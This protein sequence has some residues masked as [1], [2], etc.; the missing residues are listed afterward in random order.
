MAFAGFPKQTIAFLSGLSSHNDKAWFEKHRADYDD[1]FVAVGRAFAE[2]MAAPLRKIDP[3]VH[4]EPASLMR[5]YRDT[6][7]A[8]DKRP[9]KDHL[10]LWFWTGKKKG[11]DASGFFFR[12]SKNEVMLGCGMHAFSPKTLAAYRRAAL[13][14]RT[15]AKL[16]GIIKKLKNAGYDVGQVGYKKVPKGVDP[17]HPREE[18]LRFNSLH[19][20]WQAPHPKALSSAAFASFVAGHFAKIAPLHEWLKSL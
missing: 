20:G 1:H 3:A 9:Y 13:D 14:D 16:V 19:A 18:L 7:F 5:I 8:K 2:A 11:W 6:R 10:D 15:G 4:A 12:L 17:G